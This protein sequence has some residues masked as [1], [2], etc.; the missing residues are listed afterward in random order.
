[1]IKAR[2][3]KKIPDS[4]SETPLT[5]RESLI[6][7]IRDKVP[8]PGLPLLALLHHILSSYGLEIA[9]LSLLLKFGSYD[10]T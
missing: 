1:M 2:V 8:F 4:M 6:S 3:K 10:A 7:F 5:K 9:F